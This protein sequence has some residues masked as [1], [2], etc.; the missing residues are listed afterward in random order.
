MGAIVVIKMKLYCFE[1]KEIVDVDD[2]AQPYINCKD[3]RTEKVIGKMKQK[4]NNIDRSDNLIVPSIG[5][6]LTGLMI[7]LVVF[8]FMPNVHNQETMDEVCRQLMGEEYIAIDHD[9]GTEDK[10]WC[11]NTT[12]EIIPDNISLIQEYKKVKQ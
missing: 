2:G 1:C 9:F 3:H 12:E 5:I 8:Q 10:L 6:F 7:G 11:V 4:D